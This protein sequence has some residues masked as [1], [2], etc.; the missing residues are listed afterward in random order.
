MYKQLLTEEEYIEDQFIEGVI[1]KEEFERQIR[2]LNRDY[3]GAAEE[4][5]RDAYEEEINNWFY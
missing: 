4:A 1:T 2:E 5:A 3:Q